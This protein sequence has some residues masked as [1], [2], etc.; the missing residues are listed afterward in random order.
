[1]NSARTFTAQE[2]MQHAAAGIAYDLL[3]VRITVQ[4][5]EERFRKDGVEGAFNGVD[6]YEALQG[7]HDSVTAALSYILNPEEME[8]AAMQVRSES[9]FVIEEAGHA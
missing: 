1:M 9:G 3:R 5:I 2:L 7:I 4:D 8:Y 6:L